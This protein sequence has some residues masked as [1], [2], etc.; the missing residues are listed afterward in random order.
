MNI[1]TSQCDTFDSDTSYTIQALAVNED[2]EVIS[3]IASLEISP[4]DTARGNIA[5]GFVDYKTT[6]VAVNGLVTTQFTVEK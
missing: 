2:D 4:I 3:P 5:T 1:G 6:G